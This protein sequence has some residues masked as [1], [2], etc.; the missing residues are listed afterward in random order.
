MICAYRE[1][2]E[3]VRKRWKEMDDGGI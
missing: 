1:Y 2:V 3:E